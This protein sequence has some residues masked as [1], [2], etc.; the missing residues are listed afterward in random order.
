MKPVRLPAAATLALPRWAIYAL[1]LLYILPGLIGR[2]PWKADDAASF[3]IMW[4]M[5]QGG[6][7]DWL[8]PNIA[9]LPMPD[10]GPLAFWLGA[11]C[12][13]LFGWLLGDVLAARV[14]TILVFLLG[15]LSLWYVTFALGRR[16]DAQPLKLAFGC[17]LY[18][19][20]S[21]RDR[22]KSRMPSSA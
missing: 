11:A 21:P 17:L 6:M 20:P 5:A 15:V 18:T 10:E 7:Q 16:Q 12:I 8:W 1:G 19:S 9:G 3:G 14:S 4:T 22:Q 13:K 2:E